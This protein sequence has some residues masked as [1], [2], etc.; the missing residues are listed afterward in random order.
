MRGRATGN[1]WINSYVFNFPDGLVSQIV[2]QSETRTALLFV[3]TGQAAFISTMPNM[4]NP[5]GLI[6]GPTGVMSFAM[7]TDGELPAIRSSWFGL[8]TAPPSSL[9]IL[10]SHSLSNGGDDGLKRTERNVINL[11]E[12]LQRIQQS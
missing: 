3:F 9:Y 5:N 11:R 4:V 12:F 1:E 2:P 6:I 10:E 7:N 8:S